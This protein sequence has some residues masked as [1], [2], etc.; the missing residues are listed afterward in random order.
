MGRIT[1]SK[2]IM[3]LPWEEA[4]KVLTEALPGVD[5]EAVWVENGGKID[6]KKPKKE[7]E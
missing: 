4:K 7:G 6:K 1:I 2:E 3:A 5:V